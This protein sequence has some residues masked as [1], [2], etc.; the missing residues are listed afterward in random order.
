MY[1]NYNMPQAIIYLEEDLN[2]K[3]EHDS[4]KL[5][6]SKHDIIVRILKEKYKKG[7]LYNE[8]IR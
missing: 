7:G 4:K 2:K 8:H 5:N 3:I 1:Y 6:L